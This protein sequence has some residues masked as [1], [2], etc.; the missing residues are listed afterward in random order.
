[1]TNIDKCCNK[2]QKITI[3]NNVLINKIHKKLKKNMRKR[4]YKIIKDIL[5]RIYMLNLRNIRGYYLDY[6][7]QVNNIFII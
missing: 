7:E 1:M 6:Y 2:L 4:W 5:Y 3:N